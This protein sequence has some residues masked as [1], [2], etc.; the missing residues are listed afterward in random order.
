[1]AR[2]QRL[3]SS[4]RR[5]D[6]SAMV[7]MAVSVSILLAMLL[8]T[9]QLLFTM[10]IYQYTSDA[11]RQAT[12]WA[13]VR[14]STSCTNT[15]NLT[16]CNASATDIATYIKTLKFPGVK[17]NN[18]VTTVSWCAASGTTP[19]ISWSSCA[20]TTPNSPGNLVKVT[21]AYQVPFLPFTPNQFPTLG[22]TSQMVITQ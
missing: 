11:A 21:I 20:A 16:S 6:G 15:P 2:L 1:M 4:F 22:S 5:E 10:Y 13:M 7:E 17:V 9:M 3:L 19:P 8:G 12:R 18:V 14:G